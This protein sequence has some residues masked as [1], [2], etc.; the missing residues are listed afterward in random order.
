MRQIKPAQ[1]AFG[2]TLIYSL[3]TYLLIKTAI[4]VW[5]CANHVHVRRSSD[6]FARPSVGVPVEDVCGRPRL[7]STTGSMRPAGNRVHCRVQT[8]WSA[9]R[10]SR[11]TAGTRLPSYA[12]QRLLSLDGFQRQLKMI[13]LEDEFGADGTFVRDF[14]AE[15]LTE[16]GTED[17]RYKLR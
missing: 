7:R 10:A 6:L 2:C 3:F 4:L 9:D 8:S 16:P 1:L 15:F 11:S 12:R 17:Y 5:K 13:Y 14:S